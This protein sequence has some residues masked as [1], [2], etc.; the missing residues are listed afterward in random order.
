MTILIIHQY[1]LLPGHPGGSRFN[2]MASRWSAAGH[3]VEVIAGTMNYA[4]GERPPRY[5]W[6]LLTRELDGHVV[7][8][9]CHIPQTY[10][11]GYV[12][13]AWAFVGFM[14]SACCAVLMTK[15]PDVVIASSPPL[16]VAIPGRLAALLNRVPLVFE[17]RDLWP[18]S[19]VTTGIL[20]RSGTLTRWLYR[21]ERWAYRQS[22][23]VNVLTPAFRDNLLSRRLIPAS[24]IV[25]IPNGAD[26]STFSP[27]SRDNAARRSFGWGDRVVAMYAGAHGKANA[28]GQLVDTAERLRERPDILIATVGDGPERARWQAEAKSRG[29]K[30][31]QFCG[32][33]PKER[34]PEIVQASDIG[35]AV[36]QNN[37]TFRTVYPN[38][39]F[40]YMA[41]ERPTVL[42]IDGIA[43]QLV[44][45]EA[46]AGLY[47]PPENAEAIAC[48]ITTLADDPEERARMGRNGRNWVLAHATRDSLASTY[49]DVLDQL[50]TT[51]KATSV[52]EGK[53][54]P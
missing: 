45:D 14:I 49:L 24:K 43:R 17:V 22:A 31:I 2:E 13:R 15:R 8:W 27:E 48:A 30:N 10:N 12:G 26:V 54:S 18:E 4:T 33:Q 11:N 3:Q 38:K 23:L 40:D 6:R 35:L 20:T 1:Y 7:V 9:R 47:A 39:V 46:Q 37:P 16:T 5:A 44:C 50:V 25:C 32:P 53:A 28:I 29:L 34:M 36:L 19:A 52:S 42:A 41:C 51:G 21:I